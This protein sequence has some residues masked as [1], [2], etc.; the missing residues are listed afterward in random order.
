MYAR[1]TASERRRPAA[2][3][4]SIVWWSTVDF[5]VACKKI[6]RPVLPRCS[7][8]SP[9]HPDDSSHIFERTA[10]PLGGKTAVYMVCCAPDVTTLSSLDD[11]GEAMSA[12]CTLGSECL[13]PRRERPLLAVIATGPDLY[14][15]VSNV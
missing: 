10:A 13:L 15:A 1:V 7:T 9:L 6:Y 3:V 5:I 14:W 8:P 4:T 11:H 2:F 12:R